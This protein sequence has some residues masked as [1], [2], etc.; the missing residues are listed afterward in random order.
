LKQALSGDSFAQFLREG[1]NLFSDP[2]AEGGVGSNLY[3]TYKTNLETDLNQTQLPALQSMG[4]KHGLTG[5]SGL[6]AGLADI[7][8]NYNNNLSSTYANIAGQQQQMGLSAQS[9][10]NQN[11][12]TP[13]ALALSLA[14]TG[15]QAV[16]TSGKTTASGTMSPTVNGL[17]QQLLSQNAGLGVLSS[18]GLI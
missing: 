14:G 5:S 3:N 11:F 7:L 18:F 6:S 9:Q 10:A 17:A 13:L 15:A 2:M 4:A 1:Q 12:T 16:Q 8:K